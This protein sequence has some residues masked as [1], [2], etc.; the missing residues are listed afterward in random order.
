MIRGYQTATSYTGVLILVDNVPLNSYT[1]S[2]ATQRVGLLD[3]YDQIEV[4]KGPGS[5]LYG[6]DAFS[7][8]M[9][10][11]TWDSDKDISEYGLEYG[12]FGD[13]G[14]TFKHSQGYG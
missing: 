14:A 6:S 1:F 4:I 13:Y 7:G 10:L 9:S 11:K 3:S 12:N 2:S 5:T 8:L